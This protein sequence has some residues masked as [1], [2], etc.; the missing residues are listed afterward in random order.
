MKEI[1]IEAR[2][3]GY[4]CDIDGNIFSSK[5]K[6]ALRKSN[7]NRYWFC[8]RYYG[9][10]VSVPVHKFIAYL[11]FGDKSFSDGIEVMH[12]DNDS[13]NNSWNNIG[14]GTHTEN[15]CD[16]PKQ[17]RIERAI[18]ASNYVRSFDDNTV[19]EIINDRNQG[20]TYMQLCDKY[21]TSKSTLSYF[22]NNAQYSKK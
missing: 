13:R 19:A 9:K 12:L 5:K 1:I 10:R 6:I 22:F 21:N 18:N 15:M 3:K 14:I 17:I 8:I 7:Q 16:I 4:Y 11:K 20:F 2:K